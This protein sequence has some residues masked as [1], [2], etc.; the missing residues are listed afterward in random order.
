M[1]LEQA[2]SYIKSLLKFGINL[3]LESVDSFLLRTGYSWEGIRFIHIGGTNGKGSTAAMTAGILRQ[4]GYRVGLYSS[5]H[6]DSY[7]ERIAVDGTCISGEDFS[8]I[9]GML[10]EINRTLDENFRLTE[11]EFLT[12]MALEHFRCSQVQFAVMEVGMGG[13]FDATNVIP[14]PEVS[15]ITNV[16]KDHMQYLGNDTLSIAHEKAGII[17]QGGSL[18]TAEPSPG[19]R[20]FLEQKCRELACGFHCVYDEV[21]MEP[22]E[23]ARSSGGLTRKC[24]V[25]GSLFQLQDLNLRLLGLHQVIN[26][27]TALLVCE[28]LAQK[29]YSIS[30]ENIR[31]GLESIGIPGRIQVL[32]TNPLVIIDAGHNA[33]GIQALKSTLCEIAG[34]SRLILVT[35]MLDD[36][37]REVMAEIWGDMPSQVIVTRPDS[38]RSNG[39]REPGQFF[40]KNVTNVREIE[41]IE[42]AVDCGWDLV[43]ED[44]VLCVTGSFYVLKRARQK[45]ERLI[46]K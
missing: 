39:W 22:G 7:R 44:G 6:I 46:Y 32:A 4:A 5:P 37:E 14:C 2:E 29:G 40:R 31:S 27:S 15:V 30:N 17:R 1:D 3:G 23:Y 28:V 45:L 42:D 24:S 25:S 26:A 38:P 34:Q 36:K 13:R 9:A 35:G 11:F 33:A 43:G 20:S 19:I 8:R 10:A 41:A 18:V 12:V 21:R 16:T